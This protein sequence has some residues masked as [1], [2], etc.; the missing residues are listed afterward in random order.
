MLKLLI[1]EDVLI[2]I[3]HKLDKE[4]RVDEYEQQP[5]HCNKQYRNR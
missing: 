4:L 3:R 5:K 1:L 2:D